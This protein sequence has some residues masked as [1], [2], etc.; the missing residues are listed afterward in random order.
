M[1][2]YFYSFS[3]QNILLSS[4]QCFLVVFDEF[5]SVMRMR[6]DKLEN[7]KFNDLIVKHG[8]N[9]TCNDL[10]DIAIFN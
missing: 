4:F 7:I 10:E 9:R 1:T 8:L 2:V 3:I 5:M 6:E